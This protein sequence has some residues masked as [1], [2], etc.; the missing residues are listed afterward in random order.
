MK[1]IKLL[2]ILLSIL[3]FAAG[4]S[5][6]LETDTNNIDEVKKLIES[7]G[8]VSLDSKISII[9]AEKAYA[10]LENSEKD[11]IKNYDVLIK[12]RNEYDSL[13]REY[14]DE[15]TGIINEKIY[16]MSDMF[17][18]SRPDLGYDVDAQV[19]KNIREAREMYDA[20]D[21]AV[22][23]NVDQYALLE[24]ELLLKIYDY[25]AY[26]V[27]YASRKN[28]SSHQ[29]YSDS[30]DSEYDM[31]YEGESISDY[32]Q[33]V[34]PDLYSDMTDIYNEVARQ[35]PKKDESFADYV[36][37]LDPETYETYKEFCDNYR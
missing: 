5:A 35:V 29:Y 21:S 3:V 9:E 34:A 12:A 8:T 7:I 26:Q 24:A 33:R 23:N 17:S 27:I 32:I 4:C 2:L 20:A 25:Y 18:D 16:S 6:D 36:K 30:W 22:K 1:Y 31:P 28:K 11:Q 37:R 19:K 15:Q 14:V 13:Y 10:K